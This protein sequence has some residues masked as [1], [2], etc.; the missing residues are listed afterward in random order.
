MVTCGVQEELVAG[1]DKEEAGR[2]FFDAGADAVSPALVS[3]LDDDNGKQWLRFVPQVMNIVRNRRQKF[4][5]KGHE[6]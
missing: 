2:A 4:K 6:N 1:E 5:G 3:G